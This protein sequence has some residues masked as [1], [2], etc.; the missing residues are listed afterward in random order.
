MFENQIRRYSDE[1]TNFLPSDPGITILEYIQMFYEKQ[2]PEAVQVR[3]ESRE[4]LLEL[5]GVSLLREECAEVLVQKRNQV[6]GRMV[7]TFHKYHKFYAGDICFEPE[8]EINLYPG[9]LCGVFSEKGGELQDYTE[10]LTRKEKTFLPFGS[11]P[12]KGDCLYLQ[13]TELPAGPE[14]RR[15]LLYV[16]LDTEQERSRRNL[17]RPE[18][19]PVFARAVWSYLTEDGYEELECEDDTGVFVTEGRLGLTFGEKPPYRGE[20]GG[21]AGYI[22]SC[23]LTEAQYDRRPSV[24]EIYGPLIALKQRDTKAVVFSMEAGM[25]IPRLDMFPEEERM[26]FLYLKA[27]GESGYYECSAVQKEQLVTVPEGH[28]GIAV[29]MSKEVVLQRKL[30]VLD[31][32][33]VQIFDLSMFPGVVE[34]S[35][36]MDA[37]VCEKEGKVRHHFF[38]QQREACCGI[39]CTYNRR[40]HSVVVTYEKVFTGARVL[41]CG[42]AVSRE[43]SGNI[44]EDITFSDMGKAACMLYNPMPSAGGRGRETIEAAAQRLVCRIQTRET[45]VTEQDY[46]RLALQTPGLNIH[47]VKASCTGRDVILSVK[48]WSTEK[49]PALSGIYKKQLFAWLNKRRLLG[50][51]LQIQG[52]R[53]VPLRV[54]VDIRGRQA[55]EICRESV[56]QVI[57]EELDDIYNCRR[58]GATISFSHIYLRL[59]ALPCVIQVYELSVLPLEGRK[60]Y[61]RPG[62]DVPIDERGVCFVKELEVRM[63]KEDSL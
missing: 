32:G 13:F 21:R 50:M 38:S 57:R 63:E 26:S 3:D 10:V 46:E 36:W 9:V 45:A 14:E 18:T 37:V 59:E 34:G 47:K 60:C 25:R 40:N 49:M 29:C 1:W 48:P 2:L 58:I 56:E 28:Q 19:G 12:E 44:R 41:L 23:R 53:Y 24:Q 39:N 35:L 51:R 42:L 22:I 52:V 15:C 62:E 7:H 54:F 16:R 8:T 31:A 27:S 30:G 4:Q 55:Y 17:W 20:L 11:H 61:V 5:L 6:S 43:E 33:G